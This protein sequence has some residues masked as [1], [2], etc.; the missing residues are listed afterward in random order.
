VDLVKADTYIA[1]PFLPYIQNKLKDR[2]SQPEIKNPQRIIHMGGES[3]YGYF[4][5]FSVLLSIF[6]LHTLSF[7]LGK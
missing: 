6:P 2:E 3:K 1:F 5:P 7:P 4:L